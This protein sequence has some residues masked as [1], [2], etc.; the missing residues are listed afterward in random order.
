MAP[1]TFRPKT[2]IV[3][4]DG[5]ISFVN[6]NDP[7]I[8][9][10]K[11]NDL[12]HRILQELSKSAESRQVDHQ[13]PFV[14]EL[15]KAEIIGEYVKTES[16]MLDFKTPQLLHLLTELTN[17]CNMNCAYCY[18]EANEHH[19]E[20]RELS[21]EEWIDL[22]EKL[23][24]KSRFITQNVSLTGGEPTV[25]PSFSKIVRY[26]SGKY[27][28]EISSNGLHFK[29]EDLKAITEC[30]S[31]KFLN[32][33]MDSLRKE[34]DEQMRGRNT[35][36]RR[37]EN[38]RR[39]ASYQIPLCIGIVVSDINLESLEKTT[40]FYL[41]Q[42]PNAT[43]KYIPLTKI[44]RATRFQK[45][46]HFISGDEVVRFNEIIRKMKGEFGGRILSD[47]SNQD[48]VT[49]KWSGRCSHMKYQ[50]ESSVYQ[51]RNIGP[52]RCNAGYG[53]VDISPSGRLR[54]C[55][56]ADSFFRESLEVID[57]DT[58]MPKIAGRDMQEIGNLEFWR[59]VSSEASGFDP[60][61]TCAFKTVIKTRGARDGQ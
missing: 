55:L 48:D 28:V 61:Q 40:A 19:H 5:L 42:F 25:H 58:L 13:N 50:F 34:E 1:L 49:G 7:I 11:F 21:G 18:T 17:R 12:E 27:K 46:D 56:R 57:R 47:P 9:H 29:E 20:E 3:C 6:H 24:I 60:R 22:F 14:E 44:G 16:E 2:T 54:A 8:F 38:L 51:K 33:S 37:I 59:F 45:D 41:H 26:L 53:V 10:R 35:F 43:V 31:L 30:S 39:I 4:H 15:R 23:R 32:I 52:E 36:D